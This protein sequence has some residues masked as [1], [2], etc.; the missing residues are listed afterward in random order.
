M[1]WCLFFTIL[2]N[3]L[4]PLSSTVFEMQFSSLITLAIYNMAREFYCCY[5]ARI[6]IIFIHVY[7]RVKYSGNKCVGTR[8]MIDHSDC[9]KI[10]LQGAESWSINLW[11]VPS[12]H[13]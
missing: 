5:S 1:G 3:I 10:L 7:R 9:V 8:Y 6:A 13:C 4:R 12:L 11:L 2:T